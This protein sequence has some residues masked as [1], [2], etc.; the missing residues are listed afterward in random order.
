MVLNIIAL[1]LVLGIT[2]YHSL[3]GLFSG[4]INVFCS[5]VAVVI[6]FGFLGPVNELLTAQGLHPG[7]TEASALVG[8]FVVSLAVL[9]YLADTLLRGNV[10][11]PMYVDWVGG[12][13][14]GLINAQ[15]TVGVLVLGLLLL[16]FGGRLMMYSRYVRDADN[17]RDDR[18]LVEFR[19]ANIWV[20]SDDFTIGLVKLLSAGSLQGGNVATEAAP[21]RSFASVYP[22][23][24]QWVFWTGNT[25]QSESTPAPLRDKDGDGFKNGLTLRAWWKEPG[26]VAAQYSAERPE[27]NRD[28]PWEA[29]KVFQ[30]EADRELLGMRLALERSSSDRG[31]NQA[32]HRFRPTM[33]RV[34]GTTRGQ[35]QQ[36]FP[37]V[38]GGAPPLR[39]GKPDPGFTSQFR[40]VDIDSNLFVATSP[41][42]VD[43]F[44]EVPRD[45]EP[46][47]VEYRRHARAEVT[48]EPAKARPEA[49][50]P[51][52]PTTDGE[53][54]ETAEAPQPETVGQRTGIA[55]FMS[56]VVRE[57]SGARRELPVRV[58]QVAVAGNVE[59]SATE[60]VSGR[61][62]GDVASL[63][64]TPGAAALTEFAVPEGREMLQIR[65]RPYQAQSLIGQ[66]FN[67]A[68]RTINTY[69]AVDDVSRQYPLVGYY[70]VIQRGGQEYLELFYTGG[71]ETP[72]GIS[73][74]GLL[75]F[76][77]ISPQELTA[78]ANRAEVGLLFLVPRGVR[79]VK[80]ANQRGEG[81]E[82][83]DFA[84]P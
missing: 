28:R 73:Y 80:I 70:A 52:R 66:V 79:I 35:P 3:F 17:Q 55:G 84:V 15:L 20:R 21:D 61:L 31:Q 43:A 6:A 40:V 68:A 23:Y 63:R 9:R 14:C 45:F 75:D 11:L 37:R 69:N 78:S 32:G 59:T 62:A 64:A 27:R 2:F 51:A 42:V 50:A 13:L 48:G 4:L 49:D 74:R 25:V 71:P 60:L 77:N 1:V 83:I 44:F 53:G 58:S 72:E 18:G 22:D 76:Q 41:A 82:G 8:L 47:F 56:T 30:P 12:G 39:D 19:R 29:E 10:R 67:F 16:P 46:W 24:P 54:E 7:Y 81:I 57:Q 5:I 34:V 33:I 36:Y 38:I 26:G 65:F